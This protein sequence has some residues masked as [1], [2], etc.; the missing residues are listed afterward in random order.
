MKRIVALLSVFSLALLAA[1]PAWGTGPYSPRNAPDRASGRIDLGAVSDLDAYVDA[2][3]QLDQEP[4]AKLVVDTHG[5]ASAAQQRNQAR[6]VE[7]Q[8]DGLRSRLPGD[9]IYSLKLSANGIAVRAKVRDLI[10]V[11]GLPGVLSV[12][13]LPIHRVVNATSVPWVGTPPVWEDLGFTGSDITIGII[14]TGIDYTHAD[15]GGAG[16]A[17]AFESNDPTTLDDGGFPNAKVVGGTDF[18]GDDYNARSDDPAETIPAPD[19]D[20]LDCY[21]HGTHVAGTAAGQGV[22]SDGSTY[23]GPY[24]RDIY[25]DNDFEVGPGMAP[26]ARLYALKVFGCEGTTEVTVEAIEWALDP[27]G[28]GDI[29]DHLDVINMSLGSAFGEP[30]DPTAIAVGNAMAAG[31][32]V[33][34]AAGNAGPVPYVEDSPSVGDGI[35]VAA[36]VDGGVVNQGIEVNAPAAIAGLYEAA[37]GAITKPLDE[38]GPITGDLAV[39]QPLDACTA[40]TNGE[41]VNGNIAFIQRGTCTFASK[42][43]NAQAAGAVAVVVFNNVPGAPIV[44]GGEST[45]IEIPGVM[46]SQDDGEAFLSTMEAGAT[47]N[48]TL[49]PTFEF[50]KPELADTLASF[51]SQGPRGQDLFGPDLAAPGLSI[52]SAA[53]GTGFKG[54]LNSGTSMATPH[55][56]GLAALM[57][58]AHPS[59][60]TQVIK[61]LMMNSTVTTNGTYP[62]TLMGTGV[63]RADRALAADAYTTEAGVSFGRL[64]PASPQ[65]YT[66]TVTVNDLSGENRTYAIDNGA[67]QTLSGVDVTVPDAVEVPAN[68]S[69]SFDIRMSLDPAA[70][71]ADDGFISQTEVDGILTLTS[72][73]SSLRVGYLGVVDP[74]SDISAGRVKPGQQNM[75]SFTNDG[76]S[77]G[78]VDTFTYTGAGSGSIAAMGVRSIEDNILEFGIGSATA[79]DS[80]ARHEV[81]ILLDTDQ[82]GTP[83]YLLVAADLNLL[84]GAP[85]P[86][87]VV[88]TALIDLSSGSGNLEYYGIVDLNDQSQILPVDLRGDFGFLSKTDDDFDYV[89]VDLDAGVPVG[90]ASGHVDV[91]RDAEHIRDLAGMLPA[92]ASAQV[93]L[94]NASRER[95]LAL[96]QN[97][98]VPDQYEVITLKPGLGNR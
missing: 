46:V 33:V 73:D 72:G 96:Y 38:V 26:E 86:N 9:E 35:A 7:R 28:D 98:A 59:L 57:R 51:T 55:A 66:E 81:D 83:D 8:Q 45:G 69:A 88:V 63:I 49:D 6:K 74:A 2:F 14:D 16:T 48:V 97:N 22:L 53:I 60:H 42:I 30:G 95:L 64:N 76:E 44:M 89:V 56:A 80:P 5:R 94:L 32:L 17:A 47:V 3:I 13:R 85:Y 68:G 37:E 52:D 84:T 87:G 20:P 19:P 62:T 4:V 77:D 65:V 61:S 27:N 10:D 21:G 31:M 39:S 11:V 41:S 67:I 79:W 24:D 58:E 71:P 78:F 93:P 23:T 82:D 90:V 15:F 29:G 70:M 36:S 43:L 34:S 25:A 12:S 75:L 92:G 91:K 18:V 1:M 54:T 50:P 40:L